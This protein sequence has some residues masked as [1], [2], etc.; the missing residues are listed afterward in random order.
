MSNDSTAR[1]VWLL[2]DVEDLI[3]VHATEA[4]AELAREEHVAKVRGELSE[5][6]Q[7]AA[8]SHIGVSWRDVQD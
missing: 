1:R 5:R 7:S 8:A 3:S 4:G 6:W 2:F